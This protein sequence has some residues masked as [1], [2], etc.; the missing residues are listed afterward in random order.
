MKY[1]PFW[2][3]AMIFS[4]ANAINEVINENSTTEKNGCF[5]IIGMRIVPFDNSWAKCLDSGCRAS[6]N[7]KE[8]ICMSEPYTKQV[9]E[10]WELEEFGEHYVDMVKVFSLRSG[11]M[12]EVM[13]NESDLVD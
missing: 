7:G 12:Y 6:V 11:R 8:F 3:W 9:N 4:T 10:G 1:V 2:L 13:F 5:S